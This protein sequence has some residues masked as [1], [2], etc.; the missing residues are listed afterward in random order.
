MLTLI[1]QINLECGAIMTKLVIQQL[2]STLAGATASAT[3]GTTTAT[4]ACAFAK[5]LFNGVGKGCPLIYQ[6]GRIPKNKIKFRDYI[7]LLGVLGL[8]WSVLL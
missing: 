2:R 4:T 6:Y 8:F 7:A 3:L 5:H 1:L